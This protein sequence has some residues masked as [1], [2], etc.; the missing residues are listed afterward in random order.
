MA[1]G[2]DNDGWP[3]LEDLKRRLNLLDLST[4]DEEANVV[5]VAAIGQIKSEVGEW[6]EAVDLPTDGM[7]E[8]ALERAVELLSDVLPP[9]NERK[10]VA[11]LKGQRRRFSI[12]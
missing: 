3:S 2:G 9:M 5:L 11:L 4:H 7:A 8:A 10:S 1:F 12:A 6:D